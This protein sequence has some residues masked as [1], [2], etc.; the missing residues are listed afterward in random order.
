MDDYHQFV[1]R[2][3]SKHFA[4]L[5]LALLVSHGLIFS[6]QDPGED[7]PK[8]D[9]KWDVQRHFDENGNL[10]RYDSTYSWSWSNKNFNK[11]DLDS[12]FERFGEFPFPG[13]FLGQEF[14]EGFDGFDDFFSEDWVEHFHRLH[15]FGDDSLQNNGHLQ[16]YHPKPKKYVGREVEI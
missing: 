16:K 12:L 5:G 8:P 15:P 7:V 4:G 14:F 9:I 3:L 11:T 6:Q 13:E 2:K 1:M 10:L